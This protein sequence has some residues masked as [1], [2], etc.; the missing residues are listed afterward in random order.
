MWKLGME[1][2]H[3]NWGSNLG[4]NMLTMVHFKEFSSEFSALCDN[5]F[6]WIFWCKFKKKKA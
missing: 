3:Q 6:N 2:C 4:S 1:T 5:F